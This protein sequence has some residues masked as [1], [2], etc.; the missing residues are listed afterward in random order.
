MIIKTATLNIQDALHR[1]TGLMN[2][3]G[4]VIRLKSYFPQQDLWRFQVF[5]NKKDSRSTGWE[6]NIWLEKNDTKSPAQLNF[7]AKCLYDIV[8]N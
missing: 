6:V 1:S 3:R 4:A 7:K 5:G 2:S 8:Y